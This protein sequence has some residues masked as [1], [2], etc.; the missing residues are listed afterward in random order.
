MEKKNLTKLISYIEEF[1]SKLEK[2][3]NVD[4]KEIEQILEEIR[5]LL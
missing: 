2:G 1:S 4:E 5:K 3:L